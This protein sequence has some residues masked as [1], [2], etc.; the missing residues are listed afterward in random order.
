MRGKLSF[1]ED[2]SVSLIEVESRQMEARPTMSGS[3][4]NGQQAQKQHWFHFACRHNSPTDEMPVA[5]DYK[6]LKQREMT[7]AWQL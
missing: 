5:I 1:P 4:A 2:C 7:M 3:V 6:E